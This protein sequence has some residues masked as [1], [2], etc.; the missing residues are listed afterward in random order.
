MF[1]IKNFSSS[2]T[3]LFILSFSILTNFLGD[4]L[5]CKVQK[6]FSSNMLSKYIIIFL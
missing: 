5:S 3:F 2:Y 6:I 1:N 4:T